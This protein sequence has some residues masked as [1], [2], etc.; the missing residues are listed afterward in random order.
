M[1]M[2]FTQVGAGV[3]ALLPGAQRF[4]KSAI[5]RH[6]PVPLSDWMAAT[7]SRSTPSPYARRTLCWQNAL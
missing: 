5:R 1:L 2:W 3:N 4:W 6:D 7:R